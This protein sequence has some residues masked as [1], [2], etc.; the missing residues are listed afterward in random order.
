MPG[1]GD[2]SKAIRGSSTNA[3]SVVGKKKKPSQS[4]E[5]LTC[6][7]CN[8]AFTN[9]D[10]KLIECERCGNWNCAKCCGYN[11][12]QYNVLTTRAEIHW[13]CDNC[14]QDAILAVQSD[15]D[16]EEKCNHYMS[17][18]TK[19]IESLESKMESKANQDDLKALEA[20][21]TAVES[22]TQKENKRSTEPEK[23]EEIETKVNNMNDRKDTRLKTQL[24]ELEKDRAEI[25]K[26]RAN[27][28]MYDVSEPQ[29][30]EANFRK[31]EDTVHFNESIKKLELAIKPKFVNRIGKRE[32][33]KTHPIKIV[34]NKEQEKV[35]ILRRLHEFRT[36]SD[37]TKKTT[38]ES[39]HMVPD[40][41]LKEREQYKKL[42]KELEERRGKGEE[43][44]VIRNDR[45]VTK[46]PFQQPTEEKE[47]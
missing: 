24:A 43:N 22:V 25:E 7:L 10:D 33:G 34:L 12:V 13:Y 3:R 15:R 6:A 40:R 47:S 36:S 45:I 5:T 19:R 41:T 1:P 27:I 17:K 39:L 35:T 29:G 4:A 38:A 28:I 32:D 46:K 16:I 8:L 21:V 11:D 42:K 44:L 37:R 14:Q 20:R 30:P 18:V 23:L 9:E 26:R 31:E 2:R